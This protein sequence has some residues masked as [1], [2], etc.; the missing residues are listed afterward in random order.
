[1]AQIL[2]VVSTTPGK[3]AGS[4]AAFIVKDEQEMQAVAFTL[5]KIMDA[6]AHDLKNGSM[7]IVDH[8]NPAP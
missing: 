3:V 7:I 8:R 5:E 6:T 4:A 2:A 1:M